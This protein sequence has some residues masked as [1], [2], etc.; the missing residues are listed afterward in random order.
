MQTA[1]IHTDRT[2]TKSSPVRSALG[3]DQRSARILAKTIYRELKSSGI[4]ESSVI[5][6]ATEMLGLVT[7]DMRKAG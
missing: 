3:E 7:D 1:A 2:S 5:A 4:D 6:I